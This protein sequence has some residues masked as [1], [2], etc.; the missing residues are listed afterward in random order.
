MFDWSTKI[1]HTCLFQVLYEC[2]S[3]FKIDTV[4]VN[5]LL[6]PGEKIL[7]PI[8]FIRKLACLCMFTNR[9]DR[10]Q[11]LHV[12]VTHNLPCTRTSWWYSREIRIKNILVLEAHLYHP[13]VT[14]LRFVPL[15]NQTQSFLL[16]ARS[17]GAV[18]PCK[19]ARAGTHVALLSFSSVG[20]AGL[21]VVAVLVCSVSSCTHCP[22]LSQR[23]FE[24]SLFST[25]QQAFSYFLITSLTLSHFS[26]VLNEVWF[27]RVVSN[28]GDLQIFFLYLLYKYNKHI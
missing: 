20:V 16:P 10:R 4:F 5:D 18:G 11:R 23:G 6:A 8:D 3:L 24:V 26:F 28:S 27:L 15:W 17:E 19:A 2:L 25:D 14:S 13:K 12:I 21:S 9:E 22:S 1:C 7:N